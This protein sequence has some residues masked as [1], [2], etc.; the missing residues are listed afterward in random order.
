MS[1]QN[2]WKLSTFLCPSYSEAF[3]PRRLSGMMRLTPN[4]AMSSIA[5]PAMFSSTVVRNSCRDPFSRSTCFQRSRSVVF[6][7]RMSPSLLYAARPELIEE[8][9][10]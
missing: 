8:L 6:A 9:A 10:S 5:L 4:D 1:V 3:D 7:L 2:S